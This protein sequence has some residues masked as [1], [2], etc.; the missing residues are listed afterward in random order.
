MEEGEGRMSGCGP[1]GAD[2]DRLVQQQE[3]L[4][5]LDGELME[6]KKVPEDLRTEAMNI[7]R[8]CAEGS[9]AELRGRLED[10]QNRFDRLCETCYEAKELC[11]EATADMQTYEK[12]EK[13]FLDWLENASGKLE[14][15]TAAKKPIGIIHSE[16][17]D[18]SDFMREMEQH[19]EEY[20]QLRSLGNRLATKYKPSDALD[21]MMSSLHHQWEE[22]VSKLF[23]YLEKLHSLARKWDGYERDVKN[24]LNWIMSEAN[25]FSEEVTSRGD[26]GVEDHIQSCKLFSET[27]EGKKEDV[28]QI[29]SLANELRVEDGEKT[30]GTCDVDSRWN[31]VNQHWTS[32]CK[33]LLETLIR[34]EATYAELQHILMIRSDEFDWLGHSEREAAEQR[35]CHGDVGRVEEEIVRHQQLLSEVEGHNNEVEF[36]QATVEFLI[37]HTS[38]PGRED[39]KL[40]ADDFSR[41]YG[42]LMKSLKTYVGNLKESVPLWNEFNA[43]S[44]ELGEWLDHAHLQLTS[45][46]TQPGNAIVTETSLRNVELLL[47]ELA[48][49]EGTLDTLRALTESVAQLIPSGDKVYRRTSC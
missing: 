33:L 41:R 28:T 43:I 14:E 34:L 48:G 38:L 8:D 40:K 21:E 30:N 23:G 11:E 32:L 7:I 18:F 47:E 6:K 24:L 19:T 37:E 16:A 13:K 3:I 49:H 29:Q 9:G 46:I 4:D 45:D 17:E 20:G 10:L 35:C 25:R 5:T 1:I 36:I 44:Q 22:F 39:M 15:R 31:D 12:S 42:D 26:K 2:P 27:L